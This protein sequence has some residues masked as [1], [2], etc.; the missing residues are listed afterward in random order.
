VLWREKVAVDEKGN[1]FSYPLVIDGHAIPDGVIV[2]L[3]LYALHHNEAYFPEPFVFRPERWLENRDTSS[4]E[5]MN[6]AFAPFLI[7]PR[8]CAG[9]AM[10]YSEISLSLARTFWHFNFERAAGELGQ[11][12]GGQKGKSDGRDRP[13]EFQMWDMMTSAH[14]GPFL[15]FSPRVAE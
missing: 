2:G 1:R 14:E 10:A 6:Q 4:F 3:S 8:S 11:V 15:L 13:D 9:R 7:G 5:L 12:G